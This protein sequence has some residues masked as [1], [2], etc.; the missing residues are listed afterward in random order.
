MQTSPWLYQDVD[1]ARDDL[2]RI[3]SDDPEQIA[4][5]QTRIAHPSARRVKRNPARGAALGCLMSLAVQFLLGPVTFLARLAMFDGMLRIT[6]MFQAS[7]TVMQ[8]AGA[9]AQRLEPLVPLKQ[10]A[11]GFDLTERS[12]LLTLIVAAIAILTWLLITMPRAAVMWPRGV[13]RGCV[14]S[15]LIGLALVYVLAN[16][17]VLLLM[18]VMAGFNATMLAA[19]RFLRPQWLRAGGMWAR[20][21]APVDGSGAFQL[22]PGA[23]R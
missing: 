21:R 1:M 5:F 16:S 18:L 17:L 7:R 22:S 10:S 23:E 9:L 2:R 15:F 3:F 19:R 14:F 13:S 4:L 20:V 6:G 12:V 11:F 8:S